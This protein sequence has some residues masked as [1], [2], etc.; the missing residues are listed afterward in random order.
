[1]IKAAPTLSL[2][3]WIGAKLGLLDVKPTSLA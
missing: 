1:M 2:L 3:E